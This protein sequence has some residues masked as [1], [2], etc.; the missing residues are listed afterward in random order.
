M[1]GPIVATRRL[2]G[3][4]GLRAVPRSAALA[5]SAWTVVTLLTTS[6]V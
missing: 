1:A 5:S 4:Q 2:P 3:S 6:Q